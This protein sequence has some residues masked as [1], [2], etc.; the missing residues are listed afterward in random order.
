MCGSKRVRCKDEVEGSMAV[1][2]SYL[3]TG[4][5]KDFISWLFFVGFVADEHSY[6]VRSLRT[7]IFQR[8]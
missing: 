6:A 7:N 2:F 5:A 3:E 1:W 4:K 8:I